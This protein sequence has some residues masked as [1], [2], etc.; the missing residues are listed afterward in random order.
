MS[1]AKNLNSIQPR[2]AKNPAATLSLPSTSIAVATT[3]LPKLIKN[4]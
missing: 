3:V 1:A 2:L 4:H